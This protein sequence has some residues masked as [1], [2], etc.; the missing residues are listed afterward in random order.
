M[1]VTSDT[2]AT[3]QERLQPRQSCAG[4]LCHAL[5]APYSHALSRA[6]HS[7]LVIDLSHTRINIEHALLFQT[8][9]VIYILLFTK[10]TVTNLT[11]RPH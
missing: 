6:N 1:R 10:K 7:V 5:A 4:V 11:I 3:I 9:L 8:F 2:T